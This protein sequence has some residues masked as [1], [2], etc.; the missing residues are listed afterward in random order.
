MQL[1]QS[2]VDIGAGGGYFS[3]RFADV[4]RIEGQACVVDTN[5]ILGNYQK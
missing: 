1:G 2:I 4:V 3:I 5:R